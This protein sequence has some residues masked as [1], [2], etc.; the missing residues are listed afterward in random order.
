[1]LKQLIL[2]DRAGF[3]GLMFSADAITGQLRRC[4]SQGNASNAR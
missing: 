4:L 3:Y 1:M 2:V